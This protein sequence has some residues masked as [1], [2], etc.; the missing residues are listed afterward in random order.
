[1]EF[2]APFQPPKSVL[3][4]HFTQHYKLQTFNKFPWNETFVLFSFS[5][6]LISELLTLKGFGLGGFGLRVVTAD[7]FS[8]VLLAELLRELFFLLDFM[9]SSGFFQCWP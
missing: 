6:R 9:I 4:V 5:S 8:S 2:A 3:L 1:M 7:L